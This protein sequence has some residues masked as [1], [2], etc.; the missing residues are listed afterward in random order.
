M[1]KE[2]IMKLKEQSSL[3]GG[4]LAD[5]G[6]SDTGWLGAGD[7]RILGHDQG[8]PEPWYHQLD[9][10]QVDFPVADAV[11]L[12]S[13]IP[14]LIVIKKAEVKDLSDVLKELD[15]EIVG[16]KNSTVSMY[17]DLKK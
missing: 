16:I 2:G 13:D 4:Y 5:A 15:A 11:Y 10:E 17:N 3:T 12:P 8:K 9:F 7:T 1:G 6:E 14:K